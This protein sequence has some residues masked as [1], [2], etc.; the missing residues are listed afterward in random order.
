M[1]SYGSGSG[2]GATPRP[3]YG[4]WINEALQSN[5]PNKMKEVLQAAA[6]QYG[7]GGGPI[8]ALYGVIIDRALEGNSSKQEL[9]ALLEH[10]KAVQKSDLSGA[11]AK[12]EAHLGKSS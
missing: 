3:L 9:Q 8:T 11:I 1:S 5:D 4:V 2:G 6:Q 7:Y 10:A 12:L